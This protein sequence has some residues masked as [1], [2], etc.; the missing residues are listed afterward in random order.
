MSVFSGGD[1]HR[2]SW[3]LSQQ[4]TPLLFTFFPTFPSVSARCV[5]G[6]ARGSWLLGYLCANDQHRNQACRCNVNVDE[7]EPS[8]RACGPPLS[9]SQ[10]ARPSRSRLCILV[11]H[12]LPWHASVWSPHTSLII[13]QAQNPSFLTGSV[14]V[15]LTAI[16]HPS[17]GIPLLEPC[18]KWFSNRYH[19]STNIHRHPV[20]VRGLHLSQFQDL[21]DG[22]GENLNPFINCS[23]N[24]SFKTPRFAA[25]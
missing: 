8:V 4:L 14:N 1:F 6:L 21:V 2:A 16:L 11:R 13:P 24:G 23:L 7:L 22:E 20:L 19:H 25:S 18:Q 12:G 3:R 9:Q 17:F 5:P 15:R 10:L